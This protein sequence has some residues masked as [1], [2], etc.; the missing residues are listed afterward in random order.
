MIHGFLAITIE[1]TILLSVLFAENESFLYGA[2]FLVA[3]VLCFKLDVARNLRMGR[4]VCSHARGSFCGVINY[5]TLGLLLNRSIGKEAKYS[6]FFP[7]GFRR[8]LLLGA[9]RKLQHDCIKCSGPGR[10]SLPSWRPVRS[11]RRTM[12]AGV[13]ITRSTTAARSAPRCRRRA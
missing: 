11:P 8:F 6:C 12:T 1:L 2:G 4:C 7:C 5:E 9:G 10:N 13:T 3:A